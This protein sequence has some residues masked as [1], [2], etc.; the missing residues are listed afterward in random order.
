MFAA[1]GLL[2][3]VGSVVDSQCASLNKGFGAAGKSAI[4]R[5]F[6]G[7]DAKVTLEVGFAIKALMR[8]S[9]FSDFLG[10]PG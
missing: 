3:G 1:V 8:H 5:S 7:M 4:V 10:R 2:A 9:Q 6:V